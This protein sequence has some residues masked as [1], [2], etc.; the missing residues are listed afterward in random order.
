[1][2]NFFLFLQ[3]PV[4]EETMSLR[5]KIVEVTEVDGKADRLINIVFRGTILFL[6]VLFPSSRASFTLERSHPVSIFVPVCGTQKYIVHIRTE[7]LRIGFCC[8]S[9]GNVIFPFHSFCCSPC[10]FF[11]QKVYPRMPLG[12]KS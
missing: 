9:H 4:K 2:T 10:R 11:Q 12:Q 5:V 8:C 3:E 7:R 1:M 6:A